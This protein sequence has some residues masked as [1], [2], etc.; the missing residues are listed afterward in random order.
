MLGYKDPI[1]SDSID[2][3]DCESYVSKVNKR[4]NESQDA[5]SSITYRCIKCRSCRICKEHD[6]IE[7]SSIREEIEQDI[8]NKS[9]VV[10]TTNR[11]TMALLPLMHDPIVKLHPNG[12]KALKVYNRQIRKLNNHPKDKCDIIQSERKLQSLGHVDYGRNLPLDLQQMLKTNKIQNFIPWKAVRKTNSVSTPCRIVFDASQ[13]TSSGYSLNDILA[14][15]KNGMNKLV[16]IVIRWYTHRIAFHTDVRK[17]YNTIKLREEHWCLQRYIW[18]ENL[19]PQKLPE[20]KIIKTLIYGVKSSG[21]QS[22]LGLRQTSG[23]SK[24]Q[25]PEVHKIISEDVYVDDCLSGE[26]S[27]ETAM[28]RADQIEIVINKG[29][30]SLKGFTFSGIDPTSDLSSDGQSICVAGMLWYPKDD[31][32]SLDISDLNFARKVRGKKPTQSSGEIPIGLTRR[33][34]VSKVSEIFDITGKFTPIVAAMNL[35]CMI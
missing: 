6:A 21:N 29:G 9:V 28:E 11:I 16:E 12:N 18:Q 25:Y 26:K 5:G 3:F 31:L 35:T 33:H 8:I 24:N 1:S 22:E 13:P 34:C 10:D 15:G 23:A 4:F 20:E 14:K 27:T 32:L 7:T 19:D 17:M 30:F 2:L